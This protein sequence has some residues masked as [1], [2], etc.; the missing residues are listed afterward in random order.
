MTTNKVKTEVWGRELELKVIF[1]VYEGEV[2][3][4]NQKKALDMF[5]SNKVLFEDCSKVK[6][7]IKKKDGDEI[8]GE[9]SNIFKYVAPKSIYV[10]RD[11]KKRIVALLCDYRFDEEDGIA[12]LFENEKFVKIGTQ[13][14]IE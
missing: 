1:D 5:L 10:K 9:I 8:S 11:E 13:N 14:I 7:Y 3:L 4:D 6:G 12:L 2:I